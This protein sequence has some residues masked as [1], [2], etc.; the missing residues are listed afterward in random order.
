[1]SARL[2]LA[3]A[4]DEALSLVRVGLAP[5]LGVLVACEL[6]V[7]LAQV[8]AADR[9][10]GLETPS[11]HGTYL[12]NLVALVLMLLVPAVIGRCVFARALALHADGFAPTMRE[13]LRVPVA[14][15]AA[16]L[17]LSLV[18]LLT[19]VIGAPTVIG[20]LLCWMLAAMA[21]AACRGLAAPGPVASV[22]ALVARTAAFSA[23]W[24]LIPL[25]ALGLVL[26]T[27]DAL[28]G[29][30]AL[31]W[32]AAGIVDVQPAPWLALISSRRGILLGAAVALLLADPVLVALGVVL[33]RAAVARRSGVDLRARLVALSEGVR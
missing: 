12:R 20:P 11:H 7:L 24:L 2:R 14:E 10:L 3:D 15:L 33:S 18:L 27:I 30:A 5:W 6:P 8:H 32:I 9:L 21:P 26:L 1:M 29:F 4:L 19:G 16:T 31:A 23:T 13:A 28:A 17:M 22:S 25:L